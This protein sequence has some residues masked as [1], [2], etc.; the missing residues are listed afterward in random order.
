MSATLFQIRYNP[1]Q[2]TAF[3]AFA[4]VNGG[5]R[6]QTKDVYFVRFVGCTQPDAYL[7]EMAKLD[8]MLANKKGGEL[9]VVSFTQI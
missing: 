7:R 8:Q 5:Y 3:S 4:Q 1:M 6:Q 9:S 2:L